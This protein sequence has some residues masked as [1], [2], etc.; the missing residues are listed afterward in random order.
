MG[1]ARLA[2]P[3]SAWL[4]EG[5]FERLLPVYRPCFGYGTAQVVRGNCCTCV[6]SL[7]RGDRSTVVEAQG[8]LGPSGDGAVDARDHGYVAVDSNAGDVHAAMACDLGSD[9]S[10]RALWSRRWCAAVGTELPPREHTAPAALAAP[11][12]EAGHAASR[13]AAMAQAPWAYTTIP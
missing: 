13:A 3:D 5:D 7:H 1:L 9:S 12:V 4:S 11:Y 6:A 8:D 10:F 2:W